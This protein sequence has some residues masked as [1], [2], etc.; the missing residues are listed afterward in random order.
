MTIRKKLITTFFI[1]ICNKNC[2]AILYPKNVNPMFGEHENQIS[3]YIGMSSKVLY[4]ENFYSS[5]WRY[6]QPDHFLRL[7]G[8][9]SF[10]FGGALGFKGWN[11]IDYSQY[12]QMFFGFLQDALVLYNEKFYYGV[13]IGAYIKTR[14][15]NRISSL[16]VFGPS[17]FIGFKINDSFNTEIFFKHFSNGKFTER[18]IGQ[19]FIGFSVNY[20]FF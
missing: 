2:L 6:S 4:L 20:N 15:T 10:E 13:G 14:V 17:M 9:A 3:G 5:F 12:S 7:P 11:G 18:N 19:N 1:F 8:R 16:V